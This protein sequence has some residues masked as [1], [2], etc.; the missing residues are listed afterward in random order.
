MVAQAE[1]ASTGSHLVYSLNAAVGNHM[2]SLR[3]LSI[4][5]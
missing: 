5:P 2:I 3:N 4:E 1:V